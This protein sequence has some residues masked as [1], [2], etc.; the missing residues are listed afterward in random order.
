VNNIKFINV[1]SNAFRL[2]GDLEMPLKL[3]LNI[4]DAGM[5]A[6]SVF[7]AV[8]GIAFF[9]ILPMADFPP[10]LGIIGIL[11][12]ITA[13]G[14]FKN[15]IW[16]LWVI[17]VLFFIANTFSAYTLYYTWGRDL[18]RDISVIAYLVFTWVFTVYTSAKRKIFGS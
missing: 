14:L 2:K 18:L 11:S 5:F 3:K 8:A 1:V 12:L 10:H 7:Y 13:Y 16:T 15:R 9:V 4:R 6:A 17:V